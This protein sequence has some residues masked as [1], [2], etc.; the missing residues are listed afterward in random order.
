MDFDPEILVS[1]CCNKVLLSAHHYLLDLQ[2]LL[3]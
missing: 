2:K 3:V 1:P